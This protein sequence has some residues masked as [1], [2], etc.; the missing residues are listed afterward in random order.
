MVTSEGSGV[1]SSHPLTRFVQPHFPVAMSHKRNR[2]QMVS[3]LSMISKIIFVESHFLFEIL[4][5]D[6]GL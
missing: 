3:P 1:F 2:N 6:Y 4:H 5:K